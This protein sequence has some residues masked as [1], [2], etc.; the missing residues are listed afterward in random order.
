MSPRYQREQKVKF[1]S[2]IDLLQPYNGIVLIVGVMQDE[3][4]IVYECRSPHS[5]TF[6][7]LEAELSEV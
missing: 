2:S 4:T 5:G 3:D 6:Q 1:L 7:A